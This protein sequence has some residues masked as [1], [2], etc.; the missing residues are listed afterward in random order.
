MF[1]AAYKRVVVWKAELLSA[2]VLDYILKKGSSSESSLGQ[3]EQYP[4]LNMQ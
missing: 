4:H 2:K 3:D 1:N